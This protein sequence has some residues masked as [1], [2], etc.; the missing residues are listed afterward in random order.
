MQ[1]H[2]DQICS[3]PKSVNPL[4]D[5]FQL[6]LLSPVLPLEHLQ[7]VGEALEYPRCLLLPR[8][9]VAAIEYVAARHGGVDLWGLL[10]RGDPG[11][12]GQGELLRLLIITAET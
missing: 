4:I 8:I 9:D 3:K 12:L 6:L 7:P 2:T 1:E 10:V 5:P 11:V